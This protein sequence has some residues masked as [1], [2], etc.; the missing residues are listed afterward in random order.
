MVERWTWDRV[1]SDG[2]PVTD[3][4]YPSPV[5]WTEGTRDDGGVNIGVSSLD[6]RKTGCDG[7]PDVDSVDDSQWYTR[8]GSGGYPSRKKKK[9]KKNFTMVNKK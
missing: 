7:P 8:E 6:G 1:V 4:M 9:K 5:P 2:G 3:L